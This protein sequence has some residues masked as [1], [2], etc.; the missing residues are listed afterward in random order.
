MQ[1]LHEDLS[2]DLWTRNSTGGVN[3]TRG[4]MHR[5]GTRTYQSIR[6]LETQ[7]EESCTE[8]ARGLISRFMDSRLNWRSD[9]NSRSRVQSRHNDLSVDSW[10]QNSTRGVMCRVGTRSYQSTRGLETQLE[11]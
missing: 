7:L 9:L 2:V 8:S 3:S 10:T 4:V 1:S 11:E 6:G 5:V